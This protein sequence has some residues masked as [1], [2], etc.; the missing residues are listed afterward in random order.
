MI[1][2]DNLAVKKK[3]IYE[4]TLEL[5]KENGFHGSP[6]SLVAKNAGVAAGTIYH[7]F[8]SKD[9]LICKLYDYNKNRVDKIISEVL[10][11]DLSYKEKFLKVWQSLYAFY[12]ENNNVLI[13]F[14]QYVNS[15]YNSNKCPCYFQGE[16]F[17]FLK[18]GIETREIKSLKPEIIAVL[19]LDS[20]SSAA[21]LNSCGNISL[22]EN[23]LKQVGE[24]L[25]KGIAL[26]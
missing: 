8:E 7:Y 14:E 21:K 12:K 19:T 18:E 16:F 25:W 13:F 10:H 2:M 26:S 5:I 20:I 1:D 22:N 6:M 3:A 23:D 11:E 24:V 4:S 9:Q 17:T 15:P